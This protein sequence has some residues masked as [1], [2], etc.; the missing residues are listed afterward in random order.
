MWLFQLLLWRYLL[1][2]CFGSQQ[3]WLLVLVPVWKTMEPGS[4][5]WVA[6]LGSFL[7][8]RR[9]NCHCISRQFGHLEPGNPGNLITCS[10]WTIDVNFRVLNL[11]VLPSIHLSHLHNDYT[12]F[13]HTHTS[14]SCRFIPVSI[15][16]NP[17]LRMKLIIYYPTAK[18][19]K[20]RRSW[21]NHVQSITEIAV[22]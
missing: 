22:D 5:C 20:R 14:E 10:H 21:Y 19:P 2:V 16:S 11:A 6:K 8:I 12:S 4:C 13:T 17:N 18:P 1:K 9:T 3:Q 15:L 7:S